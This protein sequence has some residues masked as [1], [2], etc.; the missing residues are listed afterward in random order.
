MDKLLVKLVELQK[1]TCEIKLSIG[2]V[3]DSGQVMHD[4]IIVFDAAP[5][6]VTAIVNDE[7]Y[8][9]SMSHGGLMIRKSIDAILREEKEKRQK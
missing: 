1:E 5:A 7:N 2:S 9:V 3:S 8:S 4:C 6:I